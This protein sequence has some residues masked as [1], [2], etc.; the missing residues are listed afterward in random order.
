MDPPRTLREPQERPHFHA[1]IYT[2]DLM[3]PIETFGQRSAWDP[4]GW[5]CWP[6]WSLTGAGWLLATALISGVARVLRRS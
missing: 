1:L 4:V 3:L 5:T 2:L 6:A